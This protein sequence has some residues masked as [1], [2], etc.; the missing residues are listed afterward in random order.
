MYCSCFISDTRVQ[1]GVFLGPLFAILLF[2]TVIFVLIA[3]VLIRY[4]KRK[5][6]KDKELQKNTFRTTIKAMISIG[7]VMIMFG[8]SWLFGALTIDKG[9][10][11]FQWFFVILNTLQGFFLFMFFCIIGSDA[12]EEL[13]NFFT[14]NY[15]VKEQL[16]TSDS[17]TSRA[18]KRFGVLVLSHS[19]RS[20]TNSS[21]LGRKVSSS[22]LNGD[23][24]TPLDDKLSGKPVANGIMSGENCLSSQD[25][26]KGKAIMN[27]ISTQPV[28]D[29][30]PTETEPKVES[31][32]V[33]SEEDENTDSQLPPQVIYKVQRLKSDV[34]YSWET[35]KTVSL[36][37]VC[38]NLN[39]YN[40][41]LNDAQASQVE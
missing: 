11:V 32:S 10:I 35:T 31:Q 2:N 4:T 20:E 7:S 23:S 12:R 36:Q 25:V 19:S 14:C 18:P 39:S 21:S 33:T 34:L 9:S 38:Q 15:F 41:N 16:K 27:R 13:K 17:N 6:E 24:K 30:V 26:E 37:R 28:A 22:E 5:I 29:S 40:H 8:L 3:G 1:F